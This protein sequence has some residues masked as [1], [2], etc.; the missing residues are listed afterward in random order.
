MVKL[1][2]GLVCGSRSRHLSRKNMQEKSPTFPQNKHMSSSQASQFHHFLRLHTF[3]EANRWAQIPPVR[4][5]STF[6][7][8]IALFIRLGV[9]TNM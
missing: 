1:K 3:A 5:K 4:L 6:K 8:V 7:T 9:N 2:K